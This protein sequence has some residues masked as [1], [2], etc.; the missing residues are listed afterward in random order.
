MKKWLFAFMLA[1]PPAAG[2]GS[3]MYD[4]AVY[5]E[6]Y[7][8]RDTNVH[9]WHAFVCAP[10]GGGRAVGAVLDRIGRVRCTLTG[11]RT[12]AGLNVRVP[13]DCGVE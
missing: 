1:L 5:C 2:A 12:R 8:R 11:F 10:V 6:T 7:N 4:S 9:G 3:V 13:K